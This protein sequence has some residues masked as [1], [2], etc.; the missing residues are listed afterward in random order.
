M[1]RKISLTALICD[2]VERR[3]MK[4]ERLEVL[5]FLEK[6]DNIFSKV[7]N[8]INQLAKYVNG[9]KFLSQ[10]EFKNFSAQLDAIVKLK[11]KQNSIFDTI[12][13]LLSE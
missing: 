13:S 8:N 10:Q 4:D 11:E 12:Y 3:I 1:E 2:S 7:E 9:Q 6:Q 5:N